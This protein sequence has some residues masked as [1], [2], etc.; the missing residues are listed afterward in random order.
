MHITTV[1]SLYI[2]SARR[3]LQIASAQLF[4]SLCICEAEILA[5][6]RWLGLGSVGDRRW[7]RDLFAGGPRGEHVGQQ[8][9]GRRVPEQ[10]K[11][12]ICPGPLELLSPLQATVW[13]FLPLQGTVSRGSWL[14]GRAEAS[15]GGGGRHPSAEGNSQTAAPLMLS[16]MGAG[17]VGSAVRG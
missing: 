2:N 7:H 12:T 1:I 14:L 15:A 11:R 4:G 5:L 9:E 6:R 3:N 13:A 8:L 16:A 17:G 10:R